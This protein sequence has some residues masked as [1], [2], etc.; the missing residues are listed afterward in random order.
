MREREEMDGRGKETGTHRESEHITV[1][2]AGISLA[3]KT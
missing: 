2:L 3:G 1:D